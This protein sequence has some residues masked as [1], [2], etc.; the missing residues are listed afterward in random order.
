ME[1]RARFM[2]L[3]GGSDVT[4]TLAPLVNS[5]RISDAAGTHSDTCSIEVDDTDGRVILPRVGVDMIVSLG[6]QDEPATQVFVGKVDE[7]KGSGSRGGGRIISV[8]AKGID[9]LGKAKEHQQLHIDDATLE[10]AVKKAGE[11]AGITT[12]KVDEAFKSVMRP[13]WSLDGESFIAFGE[14]VAREV[15]G[16]FKIQGEKAVISKKGGGKSP[17]GAELPSVTARWGD[18]LI[19]Y[20]ITPTAGRPRFKKVRARYYDQKAAKWKETDA[21][22]EDEEAK[23]THIRRNAVADE[24]EAKGASDNDKTQSENEKGGGSVTIDGNGTATPEGSLILE[25][26]RPGIDGTYRIETV[27]HEYSRSG[28]W[29]TQLSLKKPS[30]EAG[31]DSR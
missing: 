6:W 15:G 5:I 19:S 14:R 22:I 29:T 7:V 2:V 12:V 30:G 21:E 17:S 3:I 11:K 16:I 31:K 26:A 13:Y 20:D 10:D 4:S 24:G 23:A 28:G 27:Q 1:R 9:T 25:G 8:S 18:N